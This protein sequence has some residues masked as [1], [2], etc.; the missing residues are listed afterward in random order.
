MTPSDLRALKDRLGLTYEELA[1]ALLCSRSL[2]QKML[3]GQQPIA[4]RTARLIELLSQPQ[5]QRKRR[6]G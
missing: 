6:A 2:V 3:S 1:D 4:P 5:P